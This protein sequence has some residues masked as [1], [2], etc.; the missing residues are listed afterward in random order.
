MRWLW[1]GVLC[2]GLALLGAGLAVSCGTQ[3]PQE[4]AQETPLQEKTTAD[5]SS[6]DTTSAT[7]TSPPAERPGE[8]TGSDAPG[9]EQ[10]PERTTPPPE[11]REPPKD[12]VNP[13]E[14]ADFSDLGS[15]AAEY[16]KDGTYTSLVIE[17]DYMK[18]MKP[19]QEALDAFKKALTDLQSKK[20]LRKPGGIQI[21]VD[22]EIDA[23][24]PPNGWTINLL[25]ELEIKHRQH[26]PGGAQAAAYFLYVDGP[27]HGDT[28][29]GGRV[30]GI[31]Y[32]GSTMT[33]FKKTVDDVCQS[34]AVLPG[35]ATRLCNVVE[36]STVLHEF[37]HILGLVD[38]GLAMANDHRDKDHSAHCTNKDCVMYWTNNQSSMA[39][40]LKDVIGSAPS[41]L[42]FGQECLDDMAA[43]HKP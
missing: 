30:L 38:N 20:L 13:R 32:S 29:G 25:Q 27:W 26:R 21:K 4:S 19:S 15:R 16:F 36:A 17:I 41:I 8:P 23:S 12:E 14:R 9:Q 37:G 31:A 40:S 35:T 28:K 6:S 11:R 1:R 7:D 42:P 18:G 34:A 24:I 33:L 39:D 2:C 43:L 3:Q 22:E 5:G 10:P